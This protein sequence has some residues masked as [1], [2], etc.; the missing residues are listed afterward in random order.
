MN[1]ASSMSFCPP[2][3]YTPQQNRVDER[4]NKTLIEMARTILDKYKTFDRFWVE[5]INTA[6]HAASH[7]YLNKLLKKTPYEF[8]NGN[9]PNIS[10]FRVF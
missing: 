3:S 9:K 2:P 8:L 5:V 7:L 4:K 6:C 10:Y 1:K